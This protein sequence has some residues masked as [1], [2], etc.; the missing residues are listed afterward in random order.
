MVQT[1]PKEQF[2]S[3]SRTGVFC[4]PGAGVWLWPTCTAALLATPSPLVRVE[5]RWLGDHW[6]IEAL[7]FSFSVLC[8][9]ENRN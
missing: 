4:G 1:K 6:Q 8:F 9:H 3:Q 5:S 7:G 2:S